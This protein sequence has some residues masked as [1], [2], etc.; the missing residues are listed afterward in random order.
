VVE[1]GVSPEY[2]L[3]RMKYREVS[4][5]LEAYNEKVKREMLNQRKGWYFSVLPY[6]EKGFKETDIVQ[7]TWEETP[8]AEVVDVDSEEVRKRIERL[9]QF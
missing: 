7:F 1:C 5:A 8:A 2:F 4:A 6:A 3:Y 9:N